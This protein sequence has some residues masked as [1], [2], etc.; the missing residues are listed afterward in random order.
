[1]LDCKCST[2]KRRER[3]EKKEN[4]VVILYCLDLLYLHVVPSVTSGEVKFPRLLQEFN[5][6]IGIKKSWTNVTL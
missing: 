4:Q 3:R 2:R 6:A 1:M 5:A